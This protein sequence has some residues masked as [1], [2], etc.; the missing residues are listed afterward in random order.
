MTCTAEVISS[1]TVVI[2]GL[3]PG[4][5]QP[6]TPESVEGW[7]L[8]PSSRMACVGRSPLHLPRGLYLTRGRVLRVLEL[9]AHGGKL[10]ADAVGLL[11]VARLP[12]DVAGIDGGLNRRTIY[13]TWLRSGRNILLDAFDCPDPSTITPNR[14]VTTTPTQSLSLLNNSFAL[15]M[16]DNLAERAEHDVGERPNE[17]IARVYELIYQ[18]EPSQGELD[19][20]S[21]FVDQNGLSALCRVLFNS[22]EFLYAD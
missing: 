5:I 22:N 11:E 17:Q 2:P 12:G 20:L 4:S 10:V 16:S 7:I 8:G 13:R 19:R 1:L 21:P 14:A 9:D 6:Q 3:V 15:R 18:R